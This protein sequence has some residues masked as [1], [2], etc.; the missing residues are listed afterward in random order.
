ML[1]LSTYV[2]LDLL[3]MYSVISEY[4]FCKSRSIVKVSVISD[5]LCKS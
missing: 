3:L 5:Y 1:Y 2:N 4:L